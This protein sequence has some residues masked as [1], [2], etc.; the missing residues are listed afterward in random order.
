MWLPTDFMVQDQR[1]L[2]GR[3]DILMYQ[4]EPLA[5]DLT[6]AG[7]LEADLWVSTSRGDADWIVKLIDVYPPE[8]DEQFPNAY[9]LRGYYMPVRTGVLRGRFRSS[10]SDPKPFAANEP[11]RVAVELRDV[12]H[13]FRKGHRIMVHIQSSWFPYIDRNPQKYVPN[14]FK[15]ET[16]DFVEAT[17][18]VYRSPGRPSGLKLT[19]LPPETQ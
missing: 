2:I 14:I 10:V 17:H 12:C 6:V 13:T 1:F 4:S 18:R 7:P 5:A 3:P 8:G 19:V 9:I 15:A 16:E 11:T